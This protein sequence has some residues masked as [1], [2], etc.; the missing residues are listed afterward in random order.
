[1]SLI[2]E[3]QEK[4]SF[5]K[6]YTRPRFLL[7]AVSNNTHHLTAQDKYQP[8]RD[9]WS[10]PSSGTFFFLAPGRLKATLVF[11]AWLP[12]TEQSCSDAA[13]HCVLQLSPPVY[14]VWGKNGSDMP[15]FVCLLIF[16]HVCMCVSDFVHLLLCACCVFVVFPYSFPKKSW[17]Q[18]YF[19]L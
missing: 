19:F 5:G 14:T 3:C 4:P 2:S 10:H 17:P 7:P 15:T 8:H 12:V 18:L 1:M 16:I 9:T 6:L 13:L 11:D